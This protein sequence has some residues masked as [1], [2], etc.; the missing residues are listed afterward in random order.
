M[1]PYS[2]HQGKNAPHTQTVAP[3]LSKEARNELIECESH[4]PRISKASF[5]TKEGITMNAILSY[6]PTN[7]SNDDNKDQFYK[8]LQ[9]I[10][11]ECQRKDLTILMGD[12]NAKVEMDN[13]EYE[14]I[15]G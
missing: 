8:K 11:A 12:L 4:E 9:S 5:K 14:D 1:L 7:D 3:V 10:I 6:A 13:T 15:M 2:G